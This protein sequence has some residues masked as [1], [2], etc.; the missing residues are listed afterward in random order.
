MISPDRLCDTTDLR[1]S[2]PL[3]TCEM[4]MVMVFIIIAHMLMF[5]L[6]VGQRMMIID[7]NLKVTTA[8]KVVL[9]PSS[10]P[11]GRIPGE[12][13][14]IS[15]HHFHGFHGFHG[16]FCCLFHFWIIFFVLFH[17]WIVFKSMKFYLT[18][19]DGL[20]P[21]PDL[22]PFAPSHRFTDDHVAVVALVAGGDG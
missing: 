8:C 10:Q 20:K 17:C 5:I 2:F 7:R 3:D 9:L 6:M 14:L 11:F 12:P 1:R 15:D 19:T 21:G 22:V 4:V 18:S 13:Q 16:L